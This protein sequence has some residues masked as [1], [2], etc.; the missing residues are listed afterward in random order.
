MHLSFFRRAQ[1]SVGAKKLDILQKKRYL[2]HI[3]AVTLEILNFQ[4]FQNDTRCRTTVPDPVV[5]VSRL[6]F[7]SYNPIWSQKKRTRQKR[8]PK[9]ADTPHFQRV[10]RKNKWELPAMCTSRAF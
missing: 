1:R 10:P 5:D 8:A 4:V 7:G 3:T 9:N 6:R 2:L